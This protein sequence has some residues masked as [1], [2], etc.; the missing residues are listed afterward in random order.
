MNSLKI[1]N[2]DRMKL[3][4]NLNNNSVQL[5]ITSPPYNI[6]KSYEKSVLILLKRTRK[7]SKGMF[8]FLSNKAVFVGKW[9]VIL[10]K[11]TFR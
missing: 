7:N 1:I 9:V 10:K 3:L 8:K 5:I 11:P 6:G 4:K 2:D